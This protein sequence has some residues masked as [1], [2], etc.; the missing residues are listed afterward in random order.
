MFV[1][2]ANAGLQRVI[3]KCVKPIRA[4]GCGSGGVPRAAAELSGAAQ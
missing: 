4:G 1:E 3:L 2:L